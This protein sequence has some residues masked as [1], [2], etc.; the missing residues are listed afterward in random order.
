MQSQTENQT[1]QNVQRNSLRADEPRTLTELF[2]KAVEKHNRVDALNYKKDGAWQA[3]SSTEMLSRIENIALG[4]YSLGLRKGDR[5][6]LLAANSPEWTLGDAGCQFAG[7]IDVPIYTTLAPNSVEYIIKDSG[8]RIFFLQDKETFERIKEV[9]PNCSTIEKLIFF[10]FTDVETK[11]AISLEKLEKAGEELKAE[12]PFLIGEL[13]KAIEPNDVATLI[14]TSGTTGEPKGVMLSHANL[15]ANATNTAVEFTFT[16]KDKPLSVLPL[17]HVFERSA[18]YVYILN[19]TG[20][21]YAESIEKAADNLREVAPTIFVGVPRIFEKV[22]AKA[23]LK[24]AQK[25]QLKVKIFDWAIEIAKD[26]AYKT[27]FKQPIPHLL[28][29]KHSIADH[30]VFSKLR[31]FFGGKLRFC[32]TGGAALSDDIYLTFNGAGISIMQGYGLTETS[33]VVTTNT[34]FNKRLGTVGKA[35]RNVEIR[36]ADDGEIEVSGPNVMLGYY[37]KADATK[38]A[39]TE[40]GWFRTGDIGKIDKGGFLK[41]TDRKKELFKTSGGKYIAPSPIEQMIKASRFVSQVVLVGNERKFPAA[42]IVP[43]FEQLENYARIKNLDIKTSAEFCAHPRIVNL[44]ERQVAELTENLSRFEKVKKIALLEN[45]LTVESGE[46][47]PTLKVKRRVIE[48]KYCEIIEKI[49]TDG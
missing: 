16:P 34:P 9:L 45:E 41:I 39:F 4:L 28:A 17:S 20:V 18:M 36:I 15:I 11:N 40:D 44:I 31:A 23:K 24:A 13:I 21:H 5:I 30:L 27:E 1:K 12:K 35:I 26:Y 37:K 32:I 43:N 48:E 25:S 42:L 14:Y 47:T 2:L 46:L 8:A 6:A 3:I 22:Y 7:V 38:R 10:D 33:P 49:Y 29:V 19:G